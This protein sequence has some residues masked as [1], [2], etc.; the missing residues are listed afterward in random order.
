M[1]RIA[2]NTELLMKARRS[3]SFF[4][5]QLERILREEYD[6]SSQVSLVGSAK[7]KLITYIGIF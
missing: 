7:K 3:C 1:Y 2:E 4:M 6:I 5:K